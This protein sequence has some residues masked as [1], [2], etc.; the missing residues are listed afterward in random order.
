MKKII[1]LLLVIACFVSGSALAETDI[2][3]I[4]DEFEIRSGIRYGMTIAEAKEIEDKNGI[5]CEDMEYT[6]GSIRYENISIAGIP[7]SELSFMGNGFDEEKYFDSLSNDES[8]M[9]YVEE[10]IN[11]TPLAMI[12]YMFGGIGTADQA[13]AVFSMINGSLTSKYGE[14]FTTDI[15]S[16]LY[17]ET[18]AMILDSYNNPAH[19][20]RWKIIGFSEWLVKYQDCYVLISEIADTSSYNTLCRLLYRFVSFEEMDS[21]VA[22]NQEFLNQM[23]TEMASDL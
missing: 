10:Y 9:E 11:T 17:I 19:R 3:T 6:T 4:D 2:K 23:A 12:E 21:I 13:K 16:R 5:E 1:S 14:P 15:D 22:K 7:N 8:V 20:N 18:E